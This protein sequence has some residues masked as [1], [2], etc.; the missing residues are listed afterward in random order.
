M[1][2]RVKVR[3]TAE[4]EAIKNKEKVEK[5]ARY[6]AGMSIVFEKRR[7]N[8]YDD[9][10]MTVSGRILLQNPDIY[11]LWNIR[12]EAFINNEGCFFTS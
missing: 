4:Q 11:T 1:H 10:L 3:T 8:V 7:N 12:R 9:E 5:L 6:K 2:G